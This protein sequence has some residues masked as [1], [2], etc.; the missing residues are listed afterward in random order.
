MPTTP[1]L[2]Y[3]ADCTFCTRCADWVRDHAEGS[4]NVVAWQHVADLSA[5]G[6]TPDE[7]NA[8]VYW[9]EA[10]G[11]RRSGPAAVAR[12]LESCG[13]AWWVVGQAMRTFPWTIPAE[14]LYG[15]VAHNRHLMPGG[16]D[17]CRVEPSP[18]ATARARD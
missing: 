16:T 2:I 18:L 8:R 13:A 17:A 12:A 4:V 11:R 6:L 9:I 14:L 15:V 10:D 1:V 7:A 5:Y 3:D